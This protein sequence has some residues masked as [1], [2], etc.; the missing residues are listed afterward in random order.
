[1]TKKD[2]LLILSSGLLFSAA[3]PPLPFGF[4]AYFFLFPLLIA[5]EDASPRKGFKRAYF[6]GLLSNFL[7]LYWMAW[8]FFYGETWVLPGSI[9]ALFILAIYP[10]VWGWLYCLIKKNFGN[11]ALILAPFLWVSL[12]WVRSLWEIGFPGWISAIPRPVTYL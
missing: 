6:F 2:W 3:F 12:E 11:L 8:Q 5:L 10:G 4:L 7:L 9:G 1:M